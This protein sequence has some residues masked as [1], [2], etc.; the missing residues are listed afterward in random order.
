M[1]IAP[2]KS[3]TNIGT[4]HAKLATKFK[5][6]RMFSFL[7]T[8][9]SYGREFHSANRK[10]KFIP[11]FYHTCYNNISTAKGENCRLLLICSFLAPIL[12]YPARRKCSVWKNEKPYDDKQLVFRNIPFSHRTM[13]CSRSPLLFLE[14]FKNTR[15]SIER[16][17]ERFSGEYTL[18]FFNPLFA[19][20]SICKPL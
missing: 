3:I 18:G 8:C 20:S 5:I 12:N 16:K 2:G 14:Y 6:W 9:D 4:S 17:I 19:R 10:I 7:T 15:I 13:L 11:H 1:L